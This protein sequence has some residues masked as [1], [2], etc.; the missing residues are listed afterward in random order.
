M[1]P[2]YA[3]ACCVTLWLSPMKETR[4]A[5]VS[6]P[7]WYPSIYATISQ[8]DRPARAQTAPRTSHRRRVAYCVSG[9]TET[10]GGELTS[11]M[12]GKS[13]NPWRH[14]H[15][16]AAVLRASPALRAVAAA[17]RQHACACS[18]AVLFGRS[19]DGLSTGERW[20]SRVAVPSRWDQKCA[21]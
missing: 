11:T 3:A 6:V 10:N 1:P 18:E 5:C 12:L 15:R 19:R 13:G 7:I 14:R 21:L 17:K 2:P 16:I 9:C 8:G 4:I 20:T